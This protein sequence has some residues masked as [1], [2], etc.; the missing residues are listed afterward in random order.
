MN[1]HEHGIEIRKEVIP[2]STIN[3]IKCEIESSEEEYPRHGI[4]NAEKKFQEINNLANSEAFISLA[5]SMLGSPPNIVRVIYFDKTPDKNWLVTWH[6]DKTITLNT[7]KEIEGW[8]AWSIK[9]GANHVQ[10]PLEVLNK[11]ITFR[12]HLD[13]ADENNGCLKVIPGSHKMGILRQT[14]LTNVVNSQEP[15]LCKVQEGDLVIMKPHVLHS[16]SKSSNPGHR[17][18]VHIEYSNFQLPGNL[19]WA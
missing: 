6:Q 4:R 15:Y 19:K 14:E 8:G 18:V 17:R 5:T 11:M 1:I 7:K 13:D 12:L 16:S 9:D 2:G 3:A 10:P